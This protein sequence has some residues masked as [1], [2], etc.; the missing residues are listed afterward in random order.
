M[1]EP[2]KCDNDLR[3]G[4]P[5]SPRTLLVGITAAAIAEMGLSEPSH[6]LLMPVARVVYSLCPNA[7]EPNAD[8]E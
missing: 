2:V 4:T 8:V 6:S 1:T 7:S 5:S 3:Y